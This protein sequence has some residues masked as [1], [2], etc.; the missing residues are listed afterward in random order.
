MTSRSMYVIK[1][2]IV[3]VV[4]QFKYE[5]ILNWNIF[6]FFCSWHLDD[7]FMFCVYI[8]GAK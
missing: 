2:F 7:T 1:E 4:L 5:G 8:L 3:L 6:M